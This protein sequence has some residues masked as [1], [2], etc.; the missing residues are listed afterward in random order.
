MSLA[1]FLVFTGL[2]LSNGCTKKEGESGTPSVSDKGIGPI[3]NITLGPIDSQ[4][5]SQGQQIFQSKCSACYKLDEKY[6]GPALKGVTQ[7]RT[8]EWILNQI[9][10][11]TEMTQKDPIAKELLATYLTQMTF[12]NVTE[13]EAKAILEYFRQYDSQK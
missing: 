13:E 3:K 1:V 12:Q 7:R 8:P 6:V 10:N 9:L 5:A 4:K 11:P 2:I